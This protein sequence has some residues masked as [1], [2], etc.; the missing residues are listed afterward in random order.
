MRVLGA[1]EFTYG[2][3]A[4]AVGCFLARKYHAS[5]PPRHLRR[6][7]GEYFSR[8]RSLWGA[9]DGRSGVVHSTTRSSRHCCCCCTT[10][11]CC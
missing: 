2:T 5:M 6:S 9:A 1:A 4:G 11:S 3:R 10:T 7:G 8:S